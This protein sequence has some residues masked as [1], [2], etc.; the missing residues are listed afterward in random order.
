M[1]T[2]IPALV[3]SVAAVDPPASTVALVEGGAPSQSATAKPFYSPGQTKPYTGLID[4]FQCTGASSHAMCSPMAP[5][6]EHS[7]T[8]T[9]VWQ[10]AS[11]RWLW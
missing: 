10:A 2:L 7:P 11:T 3:S 5:A 1:A 8:P 6:L 4:D 9:R